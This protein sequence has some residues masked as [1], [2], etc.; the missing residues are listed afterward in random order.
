M[1]ERIEGRGQVAKEAAARKEKAGDVEEM[2]M[3]MEMKV[4]M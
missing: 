4:E 1:T 3:D 2:E